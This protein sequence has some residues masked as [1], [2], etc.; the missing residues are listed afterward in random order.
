VSP[1]IN[2]T[3]TSGTHTR[4]SARFP[5]YRPKSFMPSTSLS[6]PLGSLRCKW[7]HET[8]AQHHLSNPDPPTILPKTCWILASP[9]MRTSPHWIP[10]RPATQSHSTDPACRAATPG[11]ERGKSGGLYTPSSM[12]VKGLRGT[13]L[14]Q[15]SP[16]IHPG[17]AYRPALAQQPACS[18]DNDGWAR[19][20]RPGGTQGQ[21]QAHPANRGLSVGSSPRG[22]Q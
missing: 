18:G 9:T 17:G 10:P 7:K 8:H 19:R 21:G 12:R 22:R 16:S 14:A 11:E 20:L 3:P 5:T 2:V 4:T 13:F 6:A 15:K 1:T